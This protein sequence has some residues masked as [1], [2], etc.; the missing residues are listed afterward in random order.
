MV[1]IQRHGGSSLSLEID[2]ADQGGNGKRV[3]RVVRNIGC[4]MA[5]R[6]EDIL[7]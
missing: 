5:V 6:R 4:R 7:E 3:G 1:V 2:F